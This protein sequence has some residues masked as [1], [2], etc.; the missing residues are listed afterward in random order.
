MIVS[1]WSLEAILF[2][3]RIW[4]Y[5]EK[6]LDKEVRTPRDKRQPSFLHGEWRT[7]SLEAGSGPGTAVSLSWDLA[8]TEDPL[9]GRCRL[10]RDHGLLGWRWPPGSSRQSGQSECQAGHV[11]SVVWKLL[12]WY[13]ALGDSFDLSFRPGMPCWHGV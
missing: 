9:S 8:K 13:T 2:Q 10:Q 4:H 5:P 1:C 12:H 3:P 11:C 7:D 6:V